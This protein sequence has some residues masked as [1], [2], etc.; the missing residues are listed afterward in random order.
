MKF[1][2][3][4]LILMFCI[5]SKVIS[6]SS[7]DTSKIIYSQ[8]WQ[9]MDYK[10]FGDDTIVL[11]SITKKQLDRKPTRGRHQKYFDYFYFDS[12]NQVKYKCH[13]PGGCPVGLPLRQLTGFRRSANQIN[14]DFSN[15]FHKSSP[16]SPFRNIEG[17]IIYEIIELKNH[18]IM[19]V[20]KT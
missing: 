12:S 17:P 7:L 4:I 18:E 20:K 2:I 15:H 16:N 19:L 9:V 1:K 13:I 6:H 5:V 8:Y 11:K 10:W 14:V 3:S